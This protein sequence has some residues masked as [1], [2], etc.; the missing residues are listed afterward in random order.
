MGRK[1]RHAPGFRADQ[2][3]GHKPDPLVR[4][5]TA[6]ADTGVIAV[7]VATHIRLLDCK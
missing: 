5:V 7:A 4:C 3:V 2:H 6:V 1:R